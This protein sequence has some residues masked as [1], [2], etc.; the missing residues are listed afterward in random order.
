[1]A[2]GVRGGQ[3]LG[4]AVTLWSEENVL[5][6]GVLAPPRCECTINMP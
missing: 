5:K 3:G 6:L 1:M 4:G 2:W